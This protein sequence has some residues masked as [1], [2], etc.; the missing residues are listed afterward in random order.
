MSFN[1]AEHATIRTWRDYQ[2]VANLPYSITSPLIQRLLLQGGPWRYLTLMIQSEVAH[3]LLPAPHGGAS[4]PLALLLQYFGTAARLFTAPALCFFPPPQVESTVIQVKRHA[5][6]P[7]ALTDTQS[8]ARFLD[9]AFSHRRK[10]VANS[11][12]ASLGGG[13]E[14]WREALASCG[15][16]ENRRAAQLSLTDYG[17][18][19]ALAQTKIGWI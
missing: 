3:K 9:A 7:F 11:L 16:G 10:T 8:F 17:A 1:Y 6:A 12:S 19:F 4:G 15:V 14:L 18:L 2:I 5:K 13:A